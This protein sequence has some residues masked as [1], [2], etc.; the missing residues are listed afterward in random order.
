L[1][2]LLLRNPGNKLPGPPAA[3]TL[4]FLFDIGDDDFS[5][6]DADAL[7]RK[8]IMAAVGGFVAENT[9]GMIVRWSK[10]L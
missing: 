3:A 7:G 10:K 5:D 2:L 6:S 1:Y 8:R 4:S 9:I